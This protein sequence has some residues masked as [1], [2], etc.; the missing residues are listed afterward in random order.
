M[1][2]ILRIDNLFFATA[3]PPD[4]KGREGS[5]EIAKSTRQDGFWKYPIID[6]GNRPKVIG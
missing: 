6:S 3:Y 2:F 1:S 4:E 5:S